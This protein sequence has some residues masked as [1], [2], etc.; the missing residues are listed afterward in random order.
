MKGFRCPDCLRAKIRS[1][2]FG[3][4]IANANKGREKPRPDSMAAKMMDSRSATLPHG[5]NNIEKAA[6]PPPTSN[7]LHN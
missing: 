4:Q 5:H 3:D 1:R 6:N 2:I 7:A